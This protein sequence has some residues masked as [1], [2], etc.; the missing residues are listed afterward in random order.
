MELQWRDKE[1]YDISMVVTRKT[2]DMN[3]HELHYENGRWLE[4]AQDRV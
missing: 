2:E 3:A 1:C 4:L